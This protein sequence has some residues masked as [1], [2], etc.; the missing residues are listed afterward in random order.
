MISRAS[1]VRPQGWG[2]LMLDPAGIAALGLR[3]VGSNVQI[4][5]C[6]RFHGASFIDIGDNVRIDD[7]CVLSAGPG[8]IRVGD[9]VHVAVYCSLIGRQTIDIDDF[10]NLS[11]RV[12]IY[13]S[14][15]DFSGASLTNPMVPDEFK[16][17]TH[18]PVR[19]R[20][21]VVVGS[22]TVVLPGVTIGE[23]SAIGALSLVKSSCDDFGIYA[24]VPAR[25]VGERRSDILVLER[26]LRAQL[27]GAAQ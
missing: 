16:Q 25:R 12:S 9:F 4:S 15:D 18:A 27:G 14:S 1:C 20:R 7:F 5:E 26:R 2:R 21:H 19:I 10:A 8:G 22:G 11:S 17:V 23:G 13:S 3:S 6:A 24:G